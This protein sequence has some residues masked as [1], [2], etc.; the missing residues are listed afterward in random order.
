MT[1]KANQK[2]LKLLKQNTVFSKQG[3][4]LFLSISEGKISFNNSRKDGKHKTL[5]ITL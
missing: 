2:Q 3:N 5:R 4:R 1:A